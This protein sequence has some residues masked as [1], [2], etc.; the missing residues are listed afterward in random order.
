MKKNTL[1]ILGSILILTSV[2][3]C[4]KDV[5]G[6][7]DFA[8]YNFSS[9]ATVGN[10]TCLYYGSLTFFFNNPSYSNVSVT[11]NGHTDSI[12][13]CFTSGNVGCGTVGCANLILPVGTYYYTAH[14][15]QKSWGVTTL[16][17]VVV[18]TNQCSLHYLQ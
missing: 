16:D 8:A 11:I 4:K 7:M 9:S 2:T 1:Y 3:S 14:S 10:G 18:D 5:A 12:P 17:S 13:Q 6:C 15:T